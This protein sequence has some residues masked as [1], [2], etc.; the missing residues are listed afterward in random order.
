[1][2]VAGVLGVEEVM[3]HSGLILGG[4]PRREGGGISDVVDLGG[5]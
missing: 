2:F 1:M 4:G 3:R 5:D